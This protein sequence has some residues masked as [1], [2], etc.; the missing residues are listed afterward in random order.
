M[1]SPQ[2]TKLFSPFPAVFTVL[3][4]A[5]V[6]IIK[7]GIILSQPNSAD[8]K[9]WFYQCFQYPPYS[10]HCVTVQGDTFPMAYS[11][12]WYAVYVPL[13]AHGYWVTNF[14]LLAADTISG[15]WIIRRSSQLFF[16]LW[17]QGS[18]YFLLAS[19]QDW[20]IWTIM[21]GGRDKKYG[22][23]FLVLAVMTKLPLIPPILNP[24]IWGYIAYNPYSLHD[25]HNW[26][27]YTLLGSFW[28]LFL[29]SWL[30]KKGLLQ[31]QVNSLY[32]HLAEWRFNHAKR[33]PQLFNRRHTDRPPSDRHRTRP[34]FNSG[35]LNLQRLNRFSSVLRSPIARHHRTTRLR[36][37]HPLRRSTTHQSRQ[38]VSSS[39]N[40]KPIPKPT[41]TANP[42]ALNPFR[43]IQRL[44]L[45]SGLFLLALLLLS[46]VSP[47]H[48]QSQYVGYAAGN[49]SGGGCPAGVSGSNPTAVA[50]QCNPVANNCEGVGIILI[51]PFAGT[52]QSISFFTTTAGGSDGLPNQ[53]IIL[54]APA[55]SLTHLSTPAG[56]CQTGG[57]GQTCGKEN[58]GD[59]FTIADVEGL[60]GLSAA[61][62]TTVILAGTVNVTPGEYIAVLIQNTG[63]QAL[64]IAPTVTA[65][66]GLT[67]AYATFI[68]F[69]NGACPISGTNTGPVAG[70]NACSDVGPASPPVMGATFQ[71]VG[72]IVPTLTQC[73]GNCGSPAVT[74]ANTNSTHTTNFNNSITLFYQFQSNLNGFVKNIT[75]NIAI[76]YSNN[77]AV[78]IGLYSTSTS[79]TATGNPFTA[80]C[81]GFLVANSQAQ[82]NPTKGVFFRNVNVQAFNGQ[83][84]AV[85]VTG[86]FKGLDLNDTNTSVLLSQTGGITPGVINTFTSL[87]TS[88]LGLYAFI[89]GNSVINGPSISGGGGCNTPTC[90]ANA[91]WIS[92]GGDTFGAIIVFLILFGIV[93]GGALY[94]TRQHDSQ[95]K[96]S[97]ALPGSVLLLIAILLL[98]GLSSIGILPPWIPVAIIMIAAAGLGGVF[99][100]KKDHGQ[101]A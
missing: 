11:L 59:T 36:S 53:F 42:K 87:G 97:F 7:L 65:G 74:L 72:T 57:P 56:Y 30:Y 66:V 78:Q 5:L 3:G 79:C 90:G 67:N 19:P 62:F 14:T 35:Y 34:R 49:C 29:A 99:Y 41:A 38:N 70:G 80:A 2:I 60:S 23:V 21:L 95:G 88:K 8:F 68:V 82:T 85:S 47:V 32:I 33:I 10:F 75:T 43:S 18:L 84:F 69:Q 61:T 24:A 52:I 55:G 16:A 17:T 100:I 45:L 6:Q 9:Y 93:G 86:F 12:L 26:A 92:L 48:A 40:E 54:T 51:A 39:R 50:G 25:W 13:T 63:N 4:L 81:P 83:W 64:L 20:L 28:L 44:S 58:A 37:H 77:Q 22:P 31:K 76:G 101:N 71:G 15:I 96:I 46:P 73:Y 27:R 89:T 1:S 91:L 94:L 98:I